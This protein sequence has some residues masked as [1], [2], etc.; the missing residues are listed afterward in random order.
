MPVKKRKNSPETIT[1]LDHDNNECDSDVEQG[2]QQ[3]G[4]LST[5]V[6]YPDFQWSWN[7]MKYSLLHTSGILLNKPTHP[8][9]WQNTSNIVLRLMTR[10]LTVSTG[11][12]LEGY[13]HPMEETALYAPVKWCSTGFHW[14]TT[15]INATSELMHVHA[16]EQMMKPLSIWCRTSMTIS[17][18]YSERHISPPKRPVTRQN[19]H[20][21][22]Q[23]SSSV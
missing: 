1:E 3:G 10:F 9:P 11:H 4:P 18:T 17:K 13:R 5:F 14:V 19:F 15:G 6:P 20:S 21:N 12:Q 16:V 22:L 7:L 2:I 23:W 8:P